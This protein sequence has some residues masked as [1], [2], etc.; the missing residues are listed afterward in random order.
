MGKT[1]GVPVLYVDGCD[2]SLDPAAAHNV[3]CNLGMRGARL[4]LLRPGDT[5]A[6]GPGTV[7]DGRGCLA[8][9]APSDA[10]AP[11]R[12]A[13][14]SPSGTSRPVVPEVPL[15][16]DVCRRLGPAAAG[17]AAAAVA[18]RV[19]AGARVL[20]GTPRG[21]GG[22]DGLLDELDWFVR[23]G[24]TPG[25]AI[26]AATTA[27]GARIEDGGPADVWLVPDGVLRDVTALRGVRHVIEGGVRVGGGGRDG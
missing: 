20:A 1:P 5:R 16:A 17:A 12:P 8:L 10:C 18:Q 9:P 24:L 6:L 14:S 27:Q 19:R 21:A 13:S 26:A 2:V 11:R 3:R 4:W 15:L 23:G 22:L 7:L 25:Q